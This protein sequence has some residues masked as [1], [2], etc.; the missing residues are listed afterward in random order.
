M[1]L[2]VIDNVPLSLKTPSGQIITLT[3]D[4]ETEAFK[5]A[6]KKSVEQCALSSMTNHIEINKAIIHALGFAAGIALG[7]LI[8]AALGGK[9]R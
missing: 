7:G 9:K 4:E 5:N 3:P 8:L 1:P 2:A 6:L